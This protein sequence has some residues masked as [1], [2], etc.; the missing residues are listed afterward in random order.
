[1]VMT[2]ISVMPMGIDNN[3]QCYGFDVLCCDC[4]YCPDERDAT[5]LREIGWTL[6]MDED[7]PRMDQPIECNNVCPRCK[8]VS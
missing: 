7:A 3:G 5:K 1:M 8:G 4:F 2:E 6:W